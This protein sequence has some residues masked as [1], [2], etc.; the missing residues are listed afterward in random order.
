[1]DHR[2]VLENLCKVCGRHVVTKSVKVKHLCTDYVDKL[3]AV[4]KILTSSDDANTHPQFSCH[5]CKIVLF[6]ASSAVKPYQHRTVVFDEWC[7]HVEG[8]CSVSTF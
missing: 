3:K 4:F 6:K 8:C 5:S 1:M 2:D 7:S